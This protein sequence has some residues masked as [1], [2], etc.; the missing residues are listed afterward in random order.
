VQVRS[1][2]CFLY[3]VSVGAS[4]S[5]QSQSV[6]VYEGSSAAGVTPWRLLWRNSERDGCLRLPVRT[7]LAVCSAPSAAQVI[8]HSLCCSVRRLSCGPSRALAPTWAA[9][10]SLL[11]CTAGPCGLG[12]AFGRARRDAVAY[13]IKY[14]PCFALCNAA[15]AAQVGRHSQS[16]ALRDGL[17]AV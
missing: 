5:D 12:R 1:L 8:K 13:R 7:C 17:I 15:S 2:A 6:A 4:T 14:G 11:G 16:V 9:T 3:D 10:V